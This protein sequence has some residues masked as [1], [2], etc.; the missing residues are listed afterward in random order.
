MPRVLLPI[1]GLL[2]MGAGWGANLM[3]AK[4]AV[5]AGAAPFGLAFTEALGSGLLLLLVCLFRKLPDLSRRHLL[6]YL[7]SGATGITIPNVLMFHVARYLP[8]GVLSLLLTLVPL[9]TYA[10]SLLLRVERFAW[11]RAAGLLVGLIAV[12]LIV[13]PAG[14]LPAPGLAGWVL[15]GFGAT[16]M[17]AVQNVYV[18]RA[19]PADSD[20]LAL[21]CGGLIVGGLLLLPV[22]VATDA[23]ISLTPPWGI[24]QWAVATM[25]AVNAVLTVIFTDLIRRVG[26]VVTSQTAY[27]I[28]IAGVLWGIALFHER[29][30]LWIWTAMLLMCLGVALVSRRS[31]AASA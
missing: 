7:V 15:L 1:A 5:G 11:I 9:A 16:A 10:L 3:L 29:H 8:V 22:T 6:F 26:P 25:L 13:A 18:A 20:A 12:G 4:F 21:S 17:F 28:T 2:V 14:S 24:V 30:S 23:M 31:R 27:L 19:W